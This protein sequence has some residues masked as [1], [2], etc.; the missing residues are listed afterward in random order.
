MSVRKPK[1][2]KPHKPHCLVGM[3]LHTFDEHGRM[4]WQG[5]IIGVDGDI[6][7]VQLFSWMT[8][9]ETNVETLAKSVIYSPNCKLYASSEEWNYS[10]D[11]INRR[12]RH[13]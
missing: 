6:C 5:K 2:Q 9:C 8:G 3:Y 13:A 1:P 10:A 4:R 12:E 7:L 11:M